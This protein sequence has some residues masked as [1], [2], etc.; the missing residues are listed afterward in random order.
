MTDTADAGQPLIDPLAQVFPSLAPDPDAGVLSLDEETEPEHQ[1]HGALGGLALAA[2]G[3]VFGDIG[4]SPLY[5]LKTVFSIEHNVVQPTHAD[6]Y[7]VISMVFWTLTIIVSF[8]YIF[9][10]MRADNDGEGGILALVALLR[11]KLAENSRF[12]GVALLLGI[13]GASLFY[14]DSVITPAISVMS[15]IEGLDVVNPA[16]TSLV[17]PLSL[18]ILTA[19]FAVQ[20]FGTGFVGRFFGPVMA[21]WFISLFVLGIP[22]VIAHPQIIAAVSPHYALEFVAREPMAAFVALGAVV[23]VVTGTEALYAD[24]GHFGRNPIRLAWFTLVFPSLVVVYMGMGAMILE[25]PTTIDN[26]FFHLAP[27]WAQIPLVVLATMATVIAS[28]AVIS[29]AFSVSRQANRLGLLPRLGVKHTSKLEGGQ[30]YISSI[31]WILFVGV[32]ML[33]VVF[34]SSESLASAY[35]L[36]VTGTLLLET[37]LFLS[38]AHLV[39][40]VGFLKLVTAVIL[41]VG[42]ELTFFVGTILKV[43]HGGWLP[44]LIASLVITV[45]TTWLKYNAVAKQRRSELEG[46]LDAFIAAVHEHSVPRVPG[47][48][49]FPHPDAATT[50]LALRQNVQFNRVLHEHVV[51][52]SI[53]NENV[54]H[55]RHVNRARVQDL[56][57]VDDGIVHVEYHIGF[58]DSQDVPKALDWAQGKLP[59]LELDPAN[60]F[61]F[62]SVLRLT[63]EGHRSI[64]TWR[65][66]LFLWLSANAASRTQVFHLPPE[67]TVVMGG[68]AGI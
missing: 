9:L 52:V 41:I 3:V 44:L 7:G 26:P 36:A 40:R 43:F 37:F 55:I 16:F 22:R 13:V 19:L 47:V 56:G 12:A 5:A 68:H 35:G 45:M 62:L 21:L 63:H 24:M 48:A 66:Q 28:Q 14:G 34:Q 8:K 61:Y 31:N 46:P 39:W 29:G 67:R 6:V 54:P 30:I 15:A 38:L 1:R 53:V 17:L 4:T 23:L 42:L 51:L 60:A 49:V 20:R 25:D 10:V 18:V 27:E 2:L 57:F 11:H 32:L 58:N 50:P 33:I 65:K 59:E 64:L